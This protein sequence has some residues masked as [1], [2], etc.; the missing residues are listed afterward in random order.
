MPLLSAAETL[1]TLQAGGIVA[2]ATET[3]FGVAANAFDPAAVMQRLNDLMYRRSRHGAFISLLLALI[4][5]GARTAA[6]L[7]AG[8]YPPLLYNPATRAAAVVEC[9]Y[10]CPLGV[11]PNQSFQAVTVPFPPGSALLGYTDGVTEATNAAGQEFGADLETLSGP[12]LPS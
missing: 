11:L 10:G 6:L 12:F 8:H 7:S 3:A 4:E 1:A 9:L 5:P 2:T